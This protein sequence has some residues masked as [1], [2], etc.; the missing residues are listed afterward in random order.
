MNNIIDSLSANMRRFDPFLAKPA[1]KYLKSYV[2]FLSLLSIFWFIMTR[3]YLFPL[4]VIFV[5]GLGI[6]TNDTAQ[7]EIYQWT[8]AQGQTHFGDRPP[9][10]RQ[11]TD[12]SEKL[13]NIN[14]S[15]ELSSPEMMLKHQ[16]LKDKER[17]R[18]HEEQQQL[19]DQDRA[20]SNTCKEAKN[21]LRK[22]KGRVVFL[23]E[24]G[25]EMNVSE[26]ERKRRAQE[27]EIAV[28]KHC[29]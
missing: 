29:L 12:I 4:A 27:M 25:R 19:I 22:L 8:D 1:R 20:V 9:H 16:Q 17:Q 23:D 15:K 18:E 28:G 2:I 21:A 10:D 14:L 13:Q 26:T 7:A 5:F 6:L 24:R 3:D 11:A